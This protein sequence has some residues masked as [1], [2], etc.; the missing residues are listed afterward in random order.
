MSKFD[1]SY[2]R[3]LFAGGQAE[4][5]QE[6][7]R[8]LM[9]MI[10]ARATDAD[11]YAHP[12]ELAAVQK[13]IKEHLGEELSAEDVTEISRSDLYKEAPLEKYISRL[14]PRLSLTQRK[15]IVSALMEVL[16]S[17]GMVAASETEYFNGVVMALRMTY[18]EVAGLA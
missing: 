17:D 2:V 4:G 13:A 15:N 9:L 8:E 18:A 7:F 16:R 10:L 14:A 6:A 3:D 1:L 5:D 11:C 12:A